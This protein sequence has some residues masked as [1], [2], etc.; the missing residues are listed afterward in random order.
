[1]RAAVK[2]MA[3]HLLPGALLLI[4]PWFSPETYWK[5]TLTVNFSDTPEQKIVWMYTSTQEGSVSVLDIHFLI[6]T[7]EDI[8][9]FTKRNEMGLV[10]IDSY[11]DAFHE[12]GLDVDF[13]A[14]G[15]SG[16]RLYVGRK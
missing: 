4:E 9:H 3:E 10:T 15:L 6:G 5:G 12:A 7:P 16:R 2:C 8:E 11:R 14:Q 13:D 1:M